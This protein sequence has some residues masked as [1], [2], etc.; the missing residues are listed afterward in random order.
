MVK[1]SNGLKAR[2][3]Q[4]EKTDEE[5]ATEQDDRAVL[6]G[7]LTVDQ[8]RDVLKLDLRGP[9]LEIAAKGGWEAVQRLLHFVDGARD[10]PPPDAEFLDD[11]RQVQRMLCAWSP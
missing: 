9:L 1:W 3:N 5:L 6:L 2:F 7:L 8:W 11:L 10:W 4:V